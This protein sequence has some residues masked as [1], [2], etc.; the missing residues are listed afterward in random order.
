MKKFRKWNSIPHPGEF[1]SFLLLMKLTFILTLAATLNVSAL[2]FSQNSKLNLSVEK[3]TLRDVFKNIEK[4]SSYRFFFS[5][6]L[7]ALDKIVSI[8][9]QDANLE[10]ILSNVLK[11][12]TATFK[13]MENNI[14][15]ISPFSQAQQQKVTGT[16]TDGTNGEPLVGVNI[17]IEGS[18]MGVIS[19][20]NG[21]FSIDAQTNAVLVFSYIGYNTEK[22]VY[23]GQTSIEV[24]LIPDI[25]KLDEVVVVGYGVSS[26][27]KLA[28]AI[29]SVSPEDLNKGS[30]SDVNQLLQGKV[31]GLNISASG[32]PNK[33]SAIVLRGASTLNSSMSPFYVIDGIPGADIATVAPDDISAID[34]LK[35]AAATSIYGNRAA[36]GVIIITTKRGKKGQMQVF[37]NGYVGTEKVS[38]ELKMM[39]ASQLRDYI[40]ANGMSFTPA[41][42]KGANTNWQKAIE[43]S[44][45]FSQNHN[46][47]ISGGTEHNNYSASINYLTKEGI[48][49]KSDLNRIIAR[50]SVEQM[51][52]NDKVKF[53]L[54]V[55]NSNST[56]NDVPYR[57][58]TILQAAKYLPVSPVKNDDGTY[59]ENFVKSGYYNPVAML[60]HSQ[61]STKTNLLIGSFNTKVQLPFG[62]NYDLNISYQSSSYLYG[63]YLDKYFTSN[64]NG[65]YDNPDPGA[66]GHTLQAFGV[67]GQANRSSFQDIKKVMETYLTWD[68]KIGDH[69]I[70]AVIGYS[71][72]DNVIGDGFDI[73]TS[74]FPVDNTAYNN[75]TLSS[76][77][78]YNNGLYFGQG[79]RYEH[80]RLISDFGRLNYN[81]KDKY[82]IQGS[83]RRDGSS[84]FGANNQWGL[85]PSIGGAWRIT[86]ESFMQNQQLIND[87]KLRGSYGVTGNSSGFN[88]LTAQFISGSKGTYYYNGV[89][90]TSAYGPTQA[91]NFDLKWEK[92]ATTNIGL[93][94]TILKGKLSGTVE[95]Y[96]KK[97][98]GMIWNYGVDPMLVPTGSIVANGGSISNKGIEVSLTVTPVTTNDFNWSS[99]INLAHNKNEITSLKNPLFQGGDSVSMVYP[100]G[101]GQ[102]GSS[103]EL[104]KQG[105][106]LGQF[107]TLEYAGKDANGVSQFIDKNGNLTINPTRADYHYEGNAQPSLIVGWSNNLKYK[108]FDLSV[109][110]RGVFGNK[111]FNATRADLFRPSTAMS[112]NILVDAASELPADGNSYKY[113]SRFIEDGS[114]IRFDNATLGYNVK[115]TS[116][117]V[118]TLRVY[119]SVNNLFVITKFKGIDPE[120]NQGG[121]APGVDYNNFYPKTRTILFG[122]NVS[123]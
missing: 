90:L 16:I 108:G 4:Q 96:D 55:S 60:N 32:D 33:P 70:N 107:F 102:S 122:V 26:R 80:S 7:K 57:S 37:Y 25:T 95:W 5:D 21:K 28:S 68:K 9:A 43:K 117:Y 20:V 69:S 74:N 75:L 53:G 67:N 31:P 98:T 97:T 71:W 94:F 13:L 84:V 52:F 11:N 123:F 88:A 113:S 27:K 81:Y 104:L 76:P 120:V 112:S 110:I 103:I 6:D 14:V 86:Q 118:K 15:I 50:L 114:Y 45:A 82:L 87:L 12:S 119:S 39:D 19:D 35:D 66:S 51:A 2:V 34:I 73:T 29:T 40:T 3:Q 41:D 101:G 77:T 65:M 47:S 17:T 58:T 78:G 49:L 99:N 62:F 121:I 79:S 22:V 64:Y 111:I 8:S 83:I 38:S 30:I 61:N 63:S 48:L 36:N 23:S 18:T 54:N 59:Y 91:A 89:G 10:S 93:D 105:H 72:Q 46:L 85:F 42:D 1:K 100:E 56:A 44:S 115:I 106:P 109:F 92:T 24:K 116:K